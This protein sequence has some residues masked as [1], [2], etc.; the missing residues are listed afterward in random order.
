MKESW[1]EE[2]FQNQQFKDDLFDLISSKTPR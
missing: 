2:Q 1:I